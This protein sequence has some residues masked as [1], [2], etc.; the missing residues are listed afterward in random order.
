MVW[1]FKN[2]SDNTVGF[3]V[4]EIFP[5]FV[6]ELFIVRHPFSVC[7]PADHKVTLRVRAEGKGIL[8]YQWFTEDDEEVRSLLYLRLCVWVMKTFLFKV[9]QPYSSVLNSVCYC[10]CNVQI[11]SVCM[12]Y[13]FCYTIN[14]S[15]KVY[16]Y[17]SPIS[18]MCLSVDYEF[19]QNMNT[20]PFV[21]GPSQQT[22]TNFQRY[23]FML[24]IHFKLFTP[25]GLT[26]LITLGNFEIQIYNTRYNQV[27]YYKL[28]SLATQLFV[29]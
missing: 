6:T 11:I 4:N 29:Q 25:V 26:Y 1:L 10:K 3:H 13:L 7:L 21:L 23:H 28:N 27:Y 22:R 14:Q 19:I 16:S 8:L 18:H 5:W 20:T 2:N 15:I 24:L 12:E 9:L 17:S